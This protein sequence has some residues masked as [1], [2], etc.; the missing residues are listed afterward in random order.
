MTSPAAY[1]IVELP[2]P[3]S[4]VYKRC[5]RIGGVLAEPTVVPIYRSALDGS[6]TEQREH[7]K[8]KA[9]PVAFAVKI[10]GETIERLYTRASAFAFIK[11]YRLRMAMERMQA[12]GW[13]E[14][15][16]R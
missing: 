7:A 11:Q 2:S 10:E 9:Q 6:D 12:R 14:S 16:E 4:F 5:I 1:L 13:G 8:E 3:G 15:L